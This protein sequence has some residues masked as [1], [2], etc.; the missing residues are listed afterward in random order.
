MVPDGPP[1]D[2]AEPTLALAKAHNWRIS[3]QQVNPKQP[4]GQSY[5]RYE[6]YKHASTIREEMEMGCRSADLPFDWNF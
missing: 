3:W 1:P 5:A 4:T 2:L 6:L